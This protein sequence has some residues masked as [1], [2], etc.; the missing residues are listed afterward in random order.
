MPEALRGRL[1]VTS[2]W[3][4]QCGHYDNAKSYNTAYCISLYLT[5][6]TL[7]VYSV[8]CIIQSYQVRTLDD[9]KPQ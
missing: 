6:L 1:F 2:K 5:E 4:E 8:N 7:W 3:L 9:R